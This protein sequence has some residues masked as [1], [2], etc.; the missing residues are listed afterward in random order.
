MCFLSFFISQ[1]NLLIRLWFPFTDTAEHAAAA[2]SNSRPLLKFK[3]HIDVFKN[4]Q[5][6]KTLVKVKTL[7]QT[8]IVMLK[9]A[10]HRLVAWVTYKEWFQEEALFGGKVA[11]E[12]WTQ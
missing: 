8:L 2:L 6:Q 3:T 7:T 9:S 12:D 5:T 1:C 4:K 10:A 11:P